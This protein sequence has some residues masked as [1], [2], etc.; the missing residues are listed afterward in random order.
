MSVENTLLF[1]VIVA[2][3]MAIV[4]A[5]NWI[6]MAPHTEFRATKKHMPCPEEGEGEGEP[7]YDVEAR[8]GIEV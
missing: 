6:V 3:L 1:W 4:S 8:E 2:V 7:R 5:A